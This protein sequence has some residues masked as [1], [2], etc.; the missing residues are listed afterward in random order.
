MIK[1][2]RSVVVLA[3]RTRLG[4]VVNLA[5][6]AIN[7]ATAEHIEAARKSNYYI[8][9]DIPRGKYSPE[10]MQDHKITAEEREVF[11]IIK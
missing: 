4:S 6:S 1:F 7:S 9:S 3:L 2:L 10:F 5:A 11:D 8:V